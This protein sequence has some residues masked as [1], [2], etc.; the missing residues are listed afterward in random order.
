MKVFMGRRLVVDTTTVGSGA[1][2]VESGVDNVV[3]G[4]TSRTE[5]TTR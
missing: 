3:E 1:T 2:V 5:V 4:M